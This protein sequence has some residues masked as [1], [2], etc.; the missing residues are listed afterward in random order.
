MGGPGEGAEHGFKRVMLLPQPC[1]TLCDP[2]DCSP[3]GDLPDTGIEPPSP[4]LQ[5]S[6]L[7]T[8]PPRKPLR[9]LV[10]L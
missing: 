5:E 2:T 9:E 8:E 4:A 10:V 6:S 3:P 1:S 7:L